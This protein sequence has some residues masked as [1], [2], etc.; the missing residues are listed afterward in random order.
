MCHYHYLFS[1]I[2]FWGGVGSD[3]PE[4]A[5]WCYFNFLEVTKGSK[6]LER[7]KI[8]VDKGNTSGCN[9]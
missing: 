2:F 5:G 9:F 8:Q 4:K 6:S 1:P 7:V 3:N